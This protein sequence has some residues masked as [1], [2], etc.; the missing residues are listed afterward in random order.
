MKNDALWEDGHVVHRTRSCLKQ[1]KDLWFLAAHVVPVFRGKKNKNIHRNLYRGYI[2]VAMNFWVS[3]QSISGTVPS[4][5]FYEPTSPK[6]SALVITYQ[7]HQKIS[8]NTIPQTFEQLTNLTSKLLPSLQARSS[9]LYF[10][11]ASWT[12]SN[13]INDPHN[14]WK[15]ELTKKTSFGK[16]SF[17]LEYRIL[18]VCLLNFGLRPGCP[19]N[20][21]R[22]CNN[23][24]AVPPARTVRGSW[25][26]AWKHRIKTQK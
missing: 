14:G 13:P 16:L 22:K 15:L 19:G 23:F 12:K 10:T 11:P 6:G 24:G 7:Y 17:F 21:F 25:Q 1:S 20:S 4:V 5:V 3:N 18:L 8:K 2:D 9:N 26:V